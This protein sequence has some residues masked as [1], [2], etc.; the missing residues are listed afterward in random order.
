[1]DAAH[2]NVVGPVGKGLEAE[3]VFFDLCW[4]RPLIKGFY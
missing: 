2:G 3:L 4:K 1:M